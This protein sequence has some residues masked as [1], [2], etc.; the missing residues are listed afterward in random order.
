MA[1]ASAIPT[2]NVYVFDASKQTK[3]ISANVS[4]LGPTIRISLNDNLLNRTSPE[5][6]KAVMGHEMGHYVLNHVGTLILYMS[7]MIPGVSVV[8][9]VGDAADFRALFGRE[10]GRTRCRR[11]RGDAL[12]RPA[13]RGGQG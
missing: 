11:S 7:L 8:P 2:D 10:M 12:V 5:E 1:K 4:G 13:R 6:T 3:R 9:V